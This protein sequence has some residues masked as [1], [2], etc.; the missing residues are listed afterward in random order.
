M[1]TEALPVDDEPLDARGCPWLHT[2]RRP[3]SHMAQRHYSRAIDSGTATL[4]CPAGVDRRGDYSV[5]ATSGAM[6]RRTEP[7]SASGVDGLAR[8]PSNTLFSGP[9]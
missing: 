6:N 5:A 2:R 7:S 8:T 4:N 1:L 9:S 3:D